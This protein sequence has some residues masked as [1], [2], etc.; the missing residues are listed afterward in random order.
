M[1]TIDRIH[2]SEREAFVAALDALA[3]CGLVWVIATMRSDFFDRLANRCP[4]WRASPTKMPATLL[5]PPDNA[6]L[7]GQIIRQPARE[8]GLRYEHDARQGR[9]ILTRLS[10]KL[11][12]KVAGV[13]PLLY[14]S[15]RPALGETWRSRR[16]DLLGLS[17]TR[18]PRVEGALGR[19]AEE[20]FRISTRK[21]AGGAADGA[22]LAGDSRA[23]RSG[24]S[25]PA[26]PSVA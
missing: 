5:L 13:L 6:E 22:S 20:I 10:M 24:A 23:G 1:F 21:C 2:M 19:R 3:R 7:R 12:S 16:T 25:G 9:R 17:R 14:F 18:R 26:R 8:A 11:P 4:A 15:A